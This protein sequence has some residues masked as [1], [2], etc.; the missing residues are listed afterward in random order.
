M[1]VLSHHMVSL[2]CNE[3]DLMMMRV[4]TLHKALGMW[5]I[6]YVS[7]TWRIVPLQGKSYV[8]QQHNPFSSSKEQGPTGPIVS[9]DLCLPTK[10][11]WLWDCSFLAPHVCIL[12]GEADLEASVGFLVWGASAFPLVV[13]AGPWPSG[14]QDH[15]KGFVLKH[16]W[17]L[18][19]QSW[20]L[21]IPWTARSNQSILKEISS[22]YSLE[23]LMLKLKLQY[24][25]HLMVAKL[26]H[27]KRPWCWGRL[28][29]EGE[30]DDRGWGGWMAS[31][32]QWTWVWAN[33]G[34][35]WW[36]G[37]PSFLQPMGLQRVRH[38]W[39][40]ELNWTSELRKSL[41][42][43]SAYGWGCVPTLLTVLPEVSQHQSLQAVEW[44]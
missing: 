32:T 1:G 36:T 30:G 34:S 4:R 35:W 37:K 40:T 44:G 17:A 28:K 18:N 3:I 22:E 11:F 20:I 8:S 5:K 43:L 41:D 21:R 39:M 29:E 38:D 15:G 2:D 25:G 12:V 24:F 6:I 19:N 26:T 23:G 16:L 13:G 27:W 10:F 42:S 9:S 14:G 31:P 33:S 7:Q